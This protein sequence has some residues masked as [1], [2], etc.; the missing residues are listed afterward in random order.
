MALLLADIS[1]DLVNLDTAARKLTHLLIHQRGTAFADLDEKPA[2]RVAMRV[3]HPL[4]AADRVSLNQAVDDLDSAAE[5]YAVHGLT[6]IDVYISIYVV[7]GCQ[8]KHIHE[9]SRG[10]RRHLRQD[11]S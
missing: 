7:V 4:C 10:H 3:R 11:R 1:P 5:R 8:R 6:F 9:F 2:D